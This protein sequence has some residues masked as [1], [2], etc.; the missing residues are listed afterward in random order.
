[1]LQVITVARGPVMAFHKEITLSDQS[2]PT[3]IPR[4]HP[5]FAGRDSTELSA[6]DVP[7]PHLDRQ[8][9]SRPLRGAKIGSRVHNIKN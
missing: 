8:L 1:M 2:N 3:G 9:W 7:A 5:F 4:S 6:M